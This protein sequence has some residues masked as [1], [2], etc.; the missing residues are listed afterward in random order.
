MPKR[1]RARGRAGVSPVVSDIMMTAIVV[2]SMSILLIWTASYAF[3]N[4]SKDAIRERL[5]FEDIWFTELPGHGKVISIY[6]YNYG[7]IDIAIDYISVEPGGR[8]ADADYVEGRGLKLYPG[9]HGRVTF[10]FAWESG[11]TYY[12]KVFTTRGSS[13]EVMAVAP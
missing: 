12:V 4:P 3:F 10:R 13:F 1:L 8:V 5:V 7:P 6:I 2:I 9:G 11:T